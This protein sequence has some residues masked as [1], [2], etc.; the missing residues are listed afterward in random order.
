MGFASNQC[1]R[2][3]RVKPMPARPRVRVARVVG[4]GTM[5]AFVASKLVLPALVCVICTW[6]VMENGA[7]SV[8]IDKLSN[9][10]TVPEPKVSL[11][12]S[13]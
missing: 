1:I 12:N 5:T 13:V 11:A 9:L 2:L 8:S 4:S 7:F 6:M 10:E 3:R